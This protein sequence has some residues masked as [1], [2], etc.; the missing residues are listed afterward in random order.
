MAP[1]CQNP[2]RLATVPERH[3]VASVPARCHTQPVAPTD[4]LQ[5]SDSGHLGARRCFIDSSHTHQLLGETSLLSN[6]RC[7]NVPNAQKN[8]RKT[9]ERHTSMF[10]VRSSEFELPVRRDRS[11][12]KS[13]VQSRPPMTTTWANLNQTR[14]IDKSDTKW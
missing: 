1:A 6:S 9:P 7:L 3:E 8:P 11:P 12:L 10:L 13:S 14:R 4:K 5:I 2:F